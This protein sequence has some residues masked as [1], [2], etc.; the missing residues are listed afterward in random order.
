[1]PIVS[2]VIVGARN[3]EQLRRNLGAVGWSLMPNRWR[4]WT[5]PAPLPAPYSHFPYRRQ[6][7]FARLDSPMTG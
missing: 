2:S 5:R 1:M 7:G 3:E 6:E 4:S